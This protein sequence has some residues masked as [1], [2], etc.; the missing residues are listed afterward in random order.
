MVA[1]VDKEKDITMRHLQ[2]LSLAAI[3]LAAAA[4]PA[5]AEDEGSCGTVAADQWM[6]EE[7]A[8]AKALELGFD[9]RSV[10]IEDSCFEIY[11]ISQTGD[12][13][14]LYMNPATGDIVKTSEE[15]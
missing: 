4:V 5:A 6:S 10:K 3:A 7:A 9:V 1:R 15:D 12:K 8:K 2:A 13:V 11:A 14:E